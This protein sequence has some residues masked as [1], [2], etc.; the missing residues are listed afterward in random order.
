MHV[1]PDETSL[2][3]QRVP[4]MHG[5]QDEQSVFTLLVRLFQRSLFATPCAQSDMECG[6]P[7]P[8]SP[9]NRHHQTQTG[10]IT[11]QLSFR[12][13]QAGAFSSRSHPANAPACVV[14]EHLFD[15][16]TCNPVD[17][18]LFCFPQ[19]KNGGR[20]R[21]DFFALSRYF[22]TSLLHYFASSI[23]NP[24]IPHHFFPKIPLRRPRLHP[25]RDRDQ[26]RRRQIRNNYRPRPHHHPIPEPQ[27]HTHQK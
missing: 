27:Q 19:N 9:P 2:A 13:K 11:S 18:S 23:S 8:L 21:Q 4:S 26:H 20:S 3:K 16:T 12:P 14:E 7:A 22:F 24:H 15:Q 1:T 17:K 5:L 25:H 6:A 10:Q